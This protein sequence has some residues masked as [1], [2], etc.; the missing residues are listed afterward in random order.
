M[1]VLRPRRLAFMIVL[2]LVFVVALSSAAYAA[3][4]APDLQTQVTTLGVDMNLLWIC[5][6]GALVM[7]MQAGFALVETGFTREK[8]AAHTMGMNVTIFGTAFTAFLVVGYALMFGGYRFTGLVRLRQGDRR[9]LGRQRQLGVP[10]GRPLLLSGKAS[11]SRGAR[12]LPLHG[13]VHG[14]DR[15]DPDGR[16]GR[17][18]EV[19][20]LRRVGLLL[21]RSTTRSSVPGRGAAVGSR[22]S[23]QLEP[24]PR[25]RR[26]R[27]IRCRAHDRRH[28]RARRCD[29]A[30]TAHRQV[31]KT[32]RPTR[33]PVTTSRWRCSA[34]SSWPSDGSAS[35]PRRRSPRPTCASQ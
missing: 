16:D 20:Q 19:E 12:V 9:S 8:N 25:L 32:A 21:P 6:G 23:A 15:D 27:R 5:V 4:A 30:R 26:L 7:F 2:S 18:L 3:D 31:S 29:G 35:T 14:H 28:R 11:R 24:R 22:S 33:S 17:A 1:Q 10:S 34:S 13:R